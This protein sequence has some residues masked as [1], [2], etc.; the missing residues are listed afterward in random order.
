MSGERPDKSEQ[1]E[2]A[3]L[4]FGENLRQARRRADLSQEELGQRAGLHR[5]EIGNLEHGRRVPRIDTLVKVAG[6]LGVPPGELIEGMTWV[7]DHERSR[8]HFIAP[9]RGLRP[10]DG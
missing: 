2:A 9:P 3:A 7:P 8:G 10:S 6:G 5:T 1:K 4:H